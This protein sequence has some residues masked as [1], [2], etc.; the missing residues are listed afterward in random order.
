MGGGLIE[1]T[2]E[3]R[4]DNRD[5]E[6]TSGW[7]D[8]SRSVSQTWHERRRFGYRRLHILL[9]REGWSVNLKKLYPCMV[10]SDNGT[11]L[12]SHAILKC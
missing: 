6:G 3:R 2:K 5:I 12:T 8:S 10:V 1:A 4:T 11:E 9:K 7:R